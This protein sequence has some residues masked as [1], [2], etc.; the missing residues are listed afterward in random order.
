MSARHFVEAFKRRARVH[1]LTAEDGERLDE[2]SG[3]YVA[4]L[5]GGGTL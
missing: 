3:R 4:T 5:R 2:I 1:E